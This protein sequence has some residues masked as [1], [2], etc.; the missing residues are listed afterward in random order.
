MVSLSSLIG[1]GAGLVLGGFASVLMSFPRT[2]S[3]GTPGEAA[4]IGIGAFL[5]TACTS[6][7]RMT[8]L[9]AARK[10]APSE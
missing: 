5:F 4:A 2:A 8:G 10:S 1:L 6:F 3:A 7:A 9:T